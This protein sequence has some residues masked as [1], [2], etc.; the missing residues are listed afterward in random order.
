VRYW[1]NALHGTNYTSLNALVLL[2][3]DGE[4]YAD[5]GVAGTLSLLPP[6]P[7][8]ALIVELAAGAGRFTPWLARRASQVLA[9][10]LIPEFIAMNRARCE[11]AG[12]SNVDFRVGDAAQFV[13]PEPGTVHLVF[14]NWLLMCLTDA[15]ARGVLKQAI[16]S[17][18][19]GGAVFLHES[20]DLDIAP[21]TAHY[22]PYSAEYPAQYRHPA[23]Y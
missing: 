11:A 12:V 13:W 16:A 20:G 14:I 22:E 1:R 8:G 21:E 7:R 15:E 19:P 23:W 3:P 9:N 4:A 17:L 18:A 5:E 2:D 10:D 6:V